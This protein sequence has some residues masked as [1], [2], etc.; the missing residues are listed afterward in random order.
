MKLY[1]ELEKPQE[2]YNVLLEPHNVIISE[3]EPV[4]KSNRHYNALCM[5][6]RESGDDGKL[7]DVWSKY[8]VLSA[9]LSIPYTFSSDSLKASGQTT[10]FLIRCQT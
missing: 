2:L 7:L 1:V 8:A 4:L 5:L 6:Y 9:A 3:V 10:I